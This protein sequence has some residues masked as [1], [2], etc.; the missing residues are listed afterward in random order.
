MRYGSLTVCLS[1]AVLVCGGTTQAD[2]VYE[3]V[4]LPA[5]NGRMQD[6]EPDYPEGDVTLGGVP[7]AIPAG[8]NNQWDC[9]TIPS[10]LT[11]FEVPVNVAGVLEDLNRGVAIAEDRFDES[12]VLKHTGRLMGSIAW[13]IVT[14]DE[15]RI[16]SSVEYAGVH[17]AGGLSSQPVTEQAKEALEEFL[18]SPEGADY[19]DNL[20]FLL[21][22]RDLNTNVMARPF[23]G[24]TDQAE[25][26][27]RRLVELHFK[28]KAE[29]ADRGQS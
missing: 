6:R 28:G 5:Y 2:L 11:T 7:F 8:G 27:I 22:A 14:E 15:V 25:K 16:G 29:E 24:I 19:R 26:D 23:L 20:E 10:G 9:N 1:L 17:Q 18:S 13:E 12:P 3:T 4:A 21:T